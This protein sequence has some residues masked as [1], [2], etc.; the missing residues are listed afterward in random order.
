MVVMPARNE[1]VQGN[2]ISTNVFSKTPSVVQDISE[3]S[4]FSGQEFFAQIGS[5][6]FWSWT[7][8]TKD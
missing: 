8:L 5:G 2:E 1:M 7:F 6:V 3:R 4:N